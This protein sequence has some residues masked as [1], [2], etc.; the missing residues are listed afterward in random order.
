MACERL[1]YFFLTA[2]VAP[3]FVG[4]LGLLLIWIARRKRITGRVNALTSTSIAEHVSLKRPEG[5]IL[6]SLFIHAG[7][8]AAAAV[9][10]LAKCMHVFVSCRLQSV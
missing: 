5:K 9:F 7:L 3:Y 2:S 4:V 8:A 1:W 10:A 6:V